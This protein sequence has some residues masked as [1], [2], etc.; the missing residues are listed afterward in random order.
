MS[1][2]F[3]YRIYNNYPKILLA[4]FTFFLILSTIYFPFFSSV[5]NFPSQFPLTNNAIFIIAVFG[6]RA[7]GGG[8][9]TR[10]VPEME[11][12]I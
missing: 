8:G 3:K 7:R 11:F 9:V 5:A 4:S 1:V 2:K 10:P 6:G 12:L